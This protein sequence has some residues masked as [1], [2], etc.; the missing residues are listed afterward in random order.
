MSSEQIDAGVDTDREAPY[1]RLI[2]EAVPRLLSQFDRESLS[3]TRGSFD[4]DHWSWKFR[5]FP[6]ILLQAG[7]IPLAWLHTHPFDGNIYFDSR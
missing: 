1:R 3:P 5:D 2:L 4:R 7:L 6:V